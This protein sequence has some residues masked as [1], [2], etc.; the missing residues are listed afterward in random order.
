MGVPA[1]AF[2]VAG[3]SYACADD[4]FTSELA[5]VI[6]IRDELDKIYSEYSNLV[7]PSVKVYK[8]WTYHPLGKSQD[9]VVKAAQKTAML[10][11]SG[12]NKS[13]TSDELI[14]ARLRTARVRLGPGQGQLLLS[15]QAS[16]GASSLRKYF[17][18]GVFEDEKCI[19][20]SSQEKY[21]KIMK[22]MKS[23]LLHYASL[24]TGWQFS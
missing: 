6:I 3:N 13:V 4:Q 18:D 22:S 19:S 1:G 15:Y 8:P 2:Y 23:L 21:K 9:E 12:A 11:F 20:T 14:L 7:A 24:R 5:I 10:I 16:K 17:W